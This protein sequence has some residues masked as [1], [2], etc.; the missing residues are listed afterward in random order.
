MTCALDPFGVE[1]L[2]PRPDE[3]VDGGVVVVR[4]RGVEHEQLPRELNCAVAVSCLREGRDAAQK[5]HD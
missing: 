2:D 5:R 1:G 3:R 4:D